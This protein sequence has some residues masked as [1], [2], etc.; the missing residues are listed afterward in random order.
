ML[1]GFFWLWFIYL[2]PFS[3]RWIPFVFQNSPLVSSPL[4]LHFSISHT[5]E[6]GFVSVLFQLS[7]GSAPKCRSCLMCPFSFCELFSEV[8]S[9]NA[10][11]RIFSIYTPRFTAPLSLL[12]SFG[13][14]RYCCFLISACCH[15]DSIELFSWLCVAF[16]FTAICHQSHKKRKKIFRCFSF[17]FDNGLFVCFCPTSLSVVS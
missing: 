11:Q 10:E 3:V 15:N 9:H 1:F 8:R 16:P 5:H 6:L 4:W 13:A 12:L 2:F 7:L 14:L 17:L